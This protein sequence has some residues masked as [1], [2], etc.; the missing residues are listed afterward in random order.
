MYLCSTRRR[1]PS[2]DLIAAMLHVGS[3][4]TCIFVDASLSATKAK[5]N[6]RSPTWFCSVTSSLVK[7]RMLGMTVSKELR[8][9][10][11]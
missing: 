2:V 3:L 9:P 1:L 7:R 5:L 8:N 10:L 11:Q 6:I 4:S